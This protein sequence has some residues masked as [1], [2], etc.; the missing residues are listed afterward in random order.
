MGGLPRSEKIS[1]HNI[2]EPFSVEPGEL[3]LVHNQRKWSRI[4]LP[5]CQI[6]E[7]CL[8]KTLCRDV[9]VSD[10][11]RPAHQA[12]E[13]CH[14]RIQVRSSQH[15]NLS[16]SKRSIVK[17]NDPKGFLLSVPH[18]ADVRGFNNAREQSCLK[19]I[20]LWFKE[21]NLVLERISREQRE[22]SE[23]RFFLLMSLATFKTFEAQPEE[24]CLHFATC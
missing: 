23:T 13:A 12:Q 1:L 14:Q 11:R 20:D 4:H 21:Q 6:C 24:P 5:V 10:E 7:I 2:R 18:R 16:G 15:M 19:Q 3:A 17:T 22:V 8:E 9:D